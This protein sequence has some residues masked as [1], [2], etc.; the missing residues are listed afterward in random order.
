AP[1]VCSETPEGDRLLARLAERCM[2]V[3]LVALGF[4]G[5]GDFWA[6][7]CAAL[8]GDEIASVALSARLGPEGAEVGVDTVPAWRGRGY[9]AAATTGWAG[10]P[11]LHGRRLFYST[12]RT[13]LPSRHVAQRLGLRFLGASLA[14]T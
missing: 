8:R 6:P 12:W 2:P 11:S 14:I 13:N 4:M 3:A 10:H 1:L 7:W 5:V 9:A